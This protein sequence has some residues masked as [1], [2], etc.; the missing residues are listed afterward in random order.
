MYKNLG[1]NQGPVC[2]V[3]VL[4]TELSQLDGMVLKHMKYIWRS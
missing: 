1:L 3:D 4:P 2:Q